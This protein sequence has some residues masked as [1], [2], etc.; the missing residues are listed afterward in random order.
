[1]DE[2]YIL[3]SGGFAKEV[4]FLIQEIN[5]AEKRFDVL[6]FIDIQASRVI[7]IGKSKVNVL[8]EEDFLS[9]TRNGRPNIAFGIGSPKI[10]G[11]LYVKYK[12]QCNFPNLIHPNSIALWD[13]IDIG[14]G[15]IITSG[16][17]FTVNIVIGCCNIFNL[18][19]TVGHDV[20]I[21]SFNV[22]NPSANI[23]GGVIIGDLNLI[24]TNAAVLQNVEIGNNSVLGAG[25]LLNKN[26]ASNSVAVGMPA[27][28]IKENI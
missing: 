14:E 26:L 21:G 27:K 3:G 13:S 5:R 6:G 2:I 28:T 23:S 15:N 12:N 8:N 20:R 17:T 16:C 10:I 11:N 4:Y 9:G 22:I 18:H 1:M 19:A 24:G 25:S 7:E